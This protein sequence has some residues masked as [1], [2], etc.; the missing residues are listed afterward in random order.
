MSLG[1]EG[2]F[3]PLKEVPSVKLKFSIDVSDSCITTVMFVSSLNLSY[4]VSGSPGLTPWARLETDNRNIK[5]V[6][7]SV[8]F[9][10]CLLSSLR[11]W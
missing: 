11:G 5:S 1:A 4:F 3:L 8:F 2:G 7:I 6:V 10:I 9:I